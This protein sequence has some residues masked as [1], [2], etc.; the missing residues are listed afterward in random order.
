MMLTCPLKSSKIIPVMKKTYTIEISDDLIEDTVRELNE[1]EYDG[2]LTV[3]LVK[4]NKELF[5]YIFRKEVFNDIIDGDILYAWNDDCFCK[6]KDYLPDWFV[7][8]RGS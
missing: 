3:E 7:F 6:I 8:K 2:K 4:S 1:L 5:D